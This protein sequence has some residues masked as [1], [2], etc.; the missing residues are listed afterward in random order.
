M[1]LEVEESFL[2]VYNEHPDSF[3]GRC[4]SQHF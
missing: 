2:N 4:V 1:R 3:K